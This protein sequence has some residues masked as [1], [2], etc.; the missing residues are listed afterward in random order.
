MA[1]ERQVDLV[2]VGS[3]IG[4]L[5]AAIVAAD[6][7]LSVLIVEKSPKLGGVTAVSGGGVWAPLTR[8]GAASNHSDT[9]EQVERYLEF[10]AAGHGSTAHRRRFVEAA[11]EAVHY[12]ADHAGVRWR[13]IRGHVDNFD[14][15]APGSVRDCRFIETAPIAGAELGDWQ[16]N[17]LRS[18]FFDYGLTTDEGRDPS[19]VDTPLPELMARRKAGDIRTCGEGL[20]AYLIKAA[21][22][23]RTVPVLVSARADSLIVEDGRVVG[24][25]VLTS[26]GE[27]A[28]RA[29]RGVV[30]ATG[31]YDW[32]TVDQQEGIPEYGSSCPPTV[33]G[34]HLVMAGEIGAAITVLPP[35]G[36]HTEFGYRLPG[37]EF[38]GSPLWRW[39]LYEAGA[40]HTVIVNDRGERFCDESWFYHQQPVLRQFD[41]VGRR[42][43]NLPAFLIFD[44]NHREQTPF[45][46]FPPGTDLPADPFLRSD[47]VAGLA[48]RLA[49]DPGTLDKTIATFNQ[50]AASGIDEEYGR[51]SK[52]FMGFLRPGPAGRNMCLGPIE[53]APFY[54]LR[55]EIGGLGANQAGLHTDDN[56]VVQHLR[57]R[58]IEGLYAVGNAAAHLDFGP[59]YISGGLIARGLAWGYV[60]ARHAASRRL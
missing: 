17:S 45:G 42:Y 48:A 21:V 37:E 49:L 4:G 41:P 24:V 23:D 2:V 39:C 43:T 60:A 15:W 40:P 46:P 8:Y 14:P 25:R 38:E 50:Y 3:G 22:V 12:L 53:R 29:P 54:G 19:G 34:D 28:V 56:A 11:P 55:L 9:P 58:P 7:G 52:S 33:T 16:D 31:G 36:M 18:R 32:R 44:Q 47:T 10:V 5:T 51:G 59:T 30:L 6:A 1:S 57:G 26:E 20:M 27:L 13:P 35:L